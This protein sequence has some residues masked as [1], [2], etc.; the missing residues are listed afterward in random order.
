MSESQK[1]VQDSPIEQAKREIRMS[2]RER[3]RTIPDSRRKEVGRAIAKK[4]CHPPISLLFK[5]RIIAVYLSTSHEI[6]TRYI[7]R[8]ANEAGIRVCVPVWDS[9]LQEYRLTLFTPEMPIVKGKYGIREPAVRE[10]IPI[11]EVDAFII[12]GLAFDPGGGR[13]GYGGGYYDSFLRSA[14]KNSLRIGICHDLQITETLLPQS[15]VDQKLHW[16]VS[17]QRVITCPRIPGRD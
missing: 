10:D 12:P 7:V 17:D 14:R 15:G 1:P 13:L 2:M 5:A 3:R 6:P 4:I 11:W 9:H 16:I 8:R